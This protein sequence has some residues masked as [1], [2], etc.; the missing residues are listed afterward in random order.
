MGRV[1]DI[2][3]DA[4][5]DKSWGK[6]VA[7]GYACMVA[8][9]MALIWGHRFVPMQDY[10]IW[11]SEGA[12]F[13]QC[14][15]GTADDNFSIVP[16]PVPNSASTAV[17]GALTLAMNVETAGKVFLSLVA[18]VFAWGAYWLTRP[19]PPLRRNAFSLIPLAWMLGFPFFHGNINYFL[20]VGVLALGGG[21]LISRADAGN[22]LRFWPVLAISVVMFFSHALM[23]AACWLLVGVYLVNPIRRG[24]WKVAA[25]ACVPS[26]L[27]SAAYLVGRAVCPMA[28]LYGPAAPAGSTTLWAKNKVTELLYYL[29][30]FGGFHAF[31]RGPWPVALA[32]AN[33]ACLLGLAVLAAVV[34][35]KARRKP[36]DRWLLAVCAVFLACW[37]A[38][39]LYLGGVSSPGQRFV[40]PALLLG[41]ALAARRPWSGKA[42][43]AA[44]AGAA[45]LLLFAAVYLVGYVGGVSEGLRDCHAR[46]VSLDTDGGVFVDEGLFRFPSRLPACRI[47]AIWRKALLPEHSV[48]GRLGYY[49]SLERGGP[50]AVFGTSILRARRNPP[51][52][53]TLEEI[54]DAAPGRL[55]LLGCDEGNARI[56]QDLSGQY[57]PLRVEPHIMVLERFSADASS[58]NHGRFESAH[59]AGLFVHPSGAQ[60]AVFA[61]DR[62]DELH[63]D[64]QARLR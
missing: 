55:I 32:V 48:L 24:Q 22:S 23:L 26:A 14:L 17:I 35:W 56:A 58:A 20:G 13:S 63:P 18:A 36:R 5:I 25:A 44:T 51:V 45:G 1:N 37:M 43:A 39:P 3:M 59:A 7:A 40:L 10:P 16:Y 54:Q 38:A 64:G 57:H 29:C 9:A 41:L 21:Y 19:P 33:A 42:R 53:R 60:E 46:L 52:P 15:R 50:G 34:A 8:V 31:Q 12:V 61:E 30:P 2:A 47:Q 6:G 4:R 62:S 49:L 28:P 11:L 27:L